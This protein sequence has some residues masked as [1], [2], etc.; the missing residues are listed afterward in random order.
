MQNNFFELDRGNFIG[1]VDAEKASLDDVS[2]VIEP[3]IV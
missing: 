2:E 3:N 1:M